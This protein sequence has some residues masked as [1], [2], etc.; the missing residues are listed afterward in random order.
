MLSLIPRKSTAEST[1]IEI[2]PSLSVVEGR[3][4]R[5]RI[6]AFRVDTSVPHSDDQMDWHN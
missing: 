5:L 3:D 2:L 6:R 1:A 4:G